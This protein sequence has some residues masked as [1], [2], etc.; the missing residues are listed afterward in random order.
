[1]V[2]RVGIRYEGVHEIVPARE[3]DDHEDGVFSIGTHVVGPPG[4]WPTRRTGILS[5][6][7]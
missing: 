1:M 2:D 4:D 6:Q 7:R 5:K 3:L